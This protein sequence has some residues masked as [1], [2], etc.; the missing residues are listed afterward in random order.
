MLGDEA[1]IALLR[2]GNAVQTFSESC[3]HDGPFFHVVRCFR[4]LLCVEPD[5]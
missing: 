5:S 4:V 2:K 1:C 3:L